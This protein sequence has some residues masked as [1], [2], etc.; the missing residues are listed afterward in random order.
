MNNTSPSPQALAASVAAQV[1]TLLG[2]LAGLFARG[3]ALLFGYSAEERAFHAYV[4]GVLQE[5]AALVD[6][7]AAGEPL[8]QPKPA[9]RRARPATSRPNRARGTPRAARAAKRP[10]IKARRITVAPPP[11]SAPPLAR[12]PARHPIAL[13]ER[14]R[15]NTPATASPLHAQIVTF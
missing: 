14:R 11:T 7:I 12:P 4:Q 2:G 15:R 1:A 9:R 13:R 5:F 10:A 3:W 6:R 8:P